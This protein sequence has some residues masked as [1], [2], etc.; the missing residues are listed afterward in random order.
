MFYM[1]TL[2]K[3]RNLL[4]ISNL[5]SSFAYT[6]VILPLLLLLIKNTSITM[7]LMHIMKDNIKIPNED[8][9]ADYMYSN[10]IYIFFL[11]KKSFIQ[12]NTYNR[13]CIS[14]VAIL[15]SFAIFK[16]YPS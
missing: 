15:S 7:H 6:I 9:I 2:L 13:K 1:Q 5:L 14:D 16:C 12:R 11:Q 3:T 8:K 10:L 4:Q